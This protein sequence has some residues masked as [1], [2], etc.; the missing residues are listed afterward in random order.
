MLRWVFVAVS[1]EA[2][3]FYIDIVHT[4]W[5]NNLYISEECGSMLIF[6]A[7]T[8]AIPWLDAG[9][10]YFK[11]LFFATVHVAIL[12]AT[13][14]SHNSILG[15]FRTNFVRWLSN[16][17]FLCIVHFIS[18]HWVIPVLWAVCECC[19]LAMIASFGAGHN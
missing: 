2:R 1:Q 19:D 9:Q 14:N 4:R 3:G 7:V 8:I 5:K 11:D 6:F 10:V 12:D 15:C 16:E 13:P 17:S 18:W